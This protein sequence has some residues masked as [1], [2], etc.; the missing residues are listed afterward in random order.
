MPRDATASARGPLIDRNEHPEWRQFLMQAALR[1]ADELTRLR[2]LETQARIAPVVPETPEEPPLDTTPP[3]VKDG[4]QEQVAGV[5]VLRTDT[6]PEPDEITG[7]TGALPA[8]ATIPID[9]G[10][11]SS[12]E[13][14]VTAP[15]EEAPPVLRMPERAKPAHESRSKPVRKIRRVKKKPAPQQETQLP[16]IFTL[17]EALFG[18][19]TGTD[20]QKPAAPPQVRSSLN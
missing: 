19:N 13:L 7:S 6:D 1:R 5:P 15:E 14:P 20:A 12:A 16:T 9:I 17:L 4:L 2:E 18:G 10:A 8:A 3:A 11:T